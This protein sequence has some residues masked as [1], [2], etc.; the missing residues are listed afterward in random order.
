ME[1]YF[2]TYSGRHVHPHCPVPGEIEILDVARALSHLC[3]FIGHTREFYS[4][5]QHSVL[6]S[7]LVPHEDALWGLLHDA[8]EAYICDLAAPVKHMPE[9]LEYR[10]MEARLMCAICE[11]FGLA[12]TMPRSVVTADRALLATEFRDVTTMNDLQ[13][14]KDECGFAPLSHLRINPWPPAIARQTFLARF[15]ELTA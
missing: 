10:V 11:R 2:R 3:R 8:S 1:T 6:V 4:V 14:I 12:P 5:A 13:W 15:A 9:M 7:Y